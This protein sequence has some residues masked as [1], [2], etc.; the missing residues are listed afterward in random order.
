MYGELVIQSSE[1][2]YR[3]FSIYISTSIYGVFD[4]GYIIGIARDC[5]NS[6]Y[7]RMVVVART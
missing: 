2:Q 6:I 7:G 3:Y 1:Y 5:Y 4:S